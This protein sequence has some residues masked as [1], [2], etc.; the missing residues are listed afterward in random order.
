MIN[1]ARSSTGRSYRLP[2]NT[3][4]DWYRAPRCV[5]NAS[6][7]GLSSTTV[8]GRAV[9]KLP[10]HSSCCG[11]VLLA[12]TPFR[13]SLRCYVMLL[14]S[15][16]RPRPPAPGIDRQPSVKV[17]HNS[18]LPSFQRRQELREAGAPTHPDTSPLPQHRRCRH[19][20]PMST[21]T[22]TGMGVRPRAMHS[23]IVSI[24]FPS[25]YLTAI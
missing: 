20:L 16:E 6:W 7:S 24:V 18:S 10:H 3:E 25:A 13:V 8:T 2:R 14:L 19:T 11:S 21:R 23:P 17:T 9:S 22:C 12:P 5:Y 15:L 4:A 1:L